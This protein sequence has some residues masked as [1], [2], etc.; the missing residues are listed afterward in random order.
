MS[1]HA[2]EWDDLDIPACLRITPEQRKAEWAKI[3]PKRLVKKSAVPRK[4][5]T[6][7]GTLKL[8]AEIE[9]KKK[10]QMK[11]LRKRKKELGALRQ[12]QANQ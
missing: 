6:D 1:Q 2:D 12:R 5:I 4:K 10:T 11:N 3:K 9:A 8:L 7:P